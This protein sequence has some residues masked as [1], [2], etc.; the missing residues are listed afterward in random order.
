[1][2][3]PIYQ[4]ISG[5]PIVTYYRSPEQ[6]WPQGY[7]NV[8]ALPNRKEA[9]KEGGEILVVSQAMLLGSG[10]INCLLRRGGV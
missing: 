7:L 1:V 2:N 9:T 3:E 8:D 5:L 10:P 4:Q 6:I